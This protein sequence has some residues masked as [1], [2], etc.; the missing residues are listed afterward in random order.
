MSKVTFLG[1]AAVGVFISYYVTSTSG[2]VLDWG[3]DVRALKNKVCVVTGAT[4]GIGR[5]I[6]LGLGEQGATVYVTG[7]TES[8]LRKTA[9]EV[10]SKGGKGIPVVVD[11]TDTDQIR[12][13]FAQVEKEQGK[14]HILVNNCFS[15]VGGI[16]SELNT[17]YWD[18]DLDWWDTVNSAGLRSH[19]IAS[20]IATPLLLKTAEEDGAPEPGL[21]VI[22]SSWGGALPLFDA[23]YGIGKAA[24]DR[25]AGDLANDLQGRP[26]HVVS[27][28]PG[29]VL[30][31]T[32]DE[33]VVTNAGATDE[34][35]A[36]FAQGESTLFQGRA[37]AA[38]AR[39]PQGT[40]RRNGKIVMT[41]DL[42]EELGFAEDD[43]TRPM[44]FRTVKF[45]AKDTPLFPLIPRF[46]KVP[47]WCIALFASRF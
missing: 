32:I 29:A 38:L 5:G 26:L 27:L 40:G 41:A 6:A 37:V 16:F 10:T 3:P 46:V 13:L 36:A 45:L 14:L 8:D 11:H 39:D 1:L 43:G 17:K 18:R 15:A 33:L 21:I 42:G 30:T 4:R 47:R 28:W 31:E 12:A 24:K 2:M 19:Y 7:R 23:A 34:A 44:T 9:D 25:M 22:V 35:R 20:Q